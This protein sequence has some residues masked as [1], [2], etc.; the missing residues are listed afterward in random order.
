MSPRVFS[1]LGCEP[2]DGPEDEVAPVSHEIVN[3]EQS[4][5]WNGPEGAD[6]VREAERFDRSM[7]PYQVHLLRAAAIA[8]ADRVLDVGCGNGASTR[9][10][11][12]A[13]SAGSV[14]GVDLS[15]VM[16]QHARGAAA[17]E[18]LGNVTFQRADAQ[19]HPFELDAFDVLISR[20]GCMFFADPVA[21]FTNIG[22]ALRSG[23]RVALVVWQDLSR[24]D[25]FR[26]VRG[27]FALG[28]DLPTPPPDAPG[29]AAFANTDRTRSILEG[30]GFVDVDFEA[31]EEPFWV[32]A[33]VD[34]AVGFA[35]RTGFARGL[36]ADV[37]DD[38]RA[39]AYDTLAG[40]LAGHLGPDGVTVG[41]AGWVVSAKRPES[42]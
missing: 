41:S 42:A 2:L 25:W 35:R 26:L 32:G 23:G 36:L 17:S 5:A 22:G 12:E 8:D 15:E 4:D 31:V 3:T 34:D 39:R 18:G 9:A 20:F 21:A 30:A 24:N 38:D 19:V 10:A 16:L 6:W 28:R 29:P 11:A 7:G 14:L 37:S 40:S 13:A 1:H 27:A 33:D